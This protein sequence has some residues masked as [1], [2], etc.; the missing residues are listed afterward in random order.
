MELRTVLFEVTGHVATV[1]L[2]RP[3]VMN[4]F[5]QEMLEEFA[6]LWH[7]VRTD[8][9]VRVVVLRGAG[10]RAFSTGM[11]VRE[12]IDRH[13]NVWSQTDPGEYLSPKLNQVWKPLVCAVHGMAAGG[14][15]YWLNEADIMICS[16]DATFFDP[17]VSY[18]LTAAL[19]PIGLAR[20]IPLGEALRIALLGLD[21]RVSA[22]R[23]LQIGLVSEVLPRERLWDRADEIA[24]IIAAKPPAA[25]QGTVRAIWE[26][27]DSTRSQ[28]LRTG[29]SYTQLGNPVG[30]AGIDR[31]T[32]PRGQWTLR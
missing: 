3:E 29:L 17:H 32:V 1:T 7:T 19:E 4:G 14:A 8:D 15:F 6:T 13:P 5:N 25:I 18:G 20:R 22:A 24:R 28:A 26:S 21:E 30:K 2:N 23:A 11:D 16:Q 31:S 9:D 27:L 12:G 10:D